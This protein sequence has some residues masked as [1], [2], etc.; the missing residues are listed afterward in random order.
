MTEWRVGPFIISREDCYRDRIPGI[1]W[2]AECWIV[3]VKVWHFGWLVCGFLGCL[4]VLQGTNG[5]NSQS[6]WWRW[7]KGT[8][9]VR[10]SR[11]FETFLPAFRLCFTFQFSTADYIASRH[12]L[13]SVL[14]W[15]VPWRRSLSSTMMATL[16]MHACMHMDDL[17]TFSTGS[18]TCS[19]RL[20]VAANICQPACMSVKRGG[21]F[22]FHYQ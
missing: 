11:L 16:R 7:G 1:D 5:S 10:M 8:A 18:H 21:P 20:G 2:M 9:S 4:P 15:H 14:V 12:S 19:T 22:G 3:L 6:W 13:P 17:Y